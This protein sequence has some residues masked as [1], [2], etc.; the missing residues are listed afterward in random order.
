MK[1]LQNFEELFMLLLADIDFEELFMFLLAD[2]DGC[3]YFIGLFVV[4]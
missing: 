2:I 1:N 3:R 4:H